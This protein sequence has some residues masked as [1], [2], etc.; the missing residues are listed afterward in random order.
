MT[1]KG[2]VALGGANR[3]NISCSL[4]QTLLKNFSTPKETPC[5]VHLVSRRGKFLGHRQ[6]ECKTH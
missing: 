2:K 1:E 6:D 3:D 5:K 4:S